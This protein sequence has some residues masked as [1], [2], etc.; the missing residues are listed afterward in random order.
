MTNNVLVVH[1]VLKWALVS[2][3]AGKRGR[4]NNWPLVILILKPSKGEAT[5]P[6]HLYPYVAC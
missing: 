2:C 6:T 4:E 1:P 3:D 5:S